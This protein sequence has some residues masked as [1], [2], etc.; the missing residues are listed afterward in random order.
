MSVHDIGACGI[1]GLKQTVLTPCMPD[2]VSAPAGAVGAPGAPD[3][4]VTL[5][6]AFPA[7]GDACG[8]AVGAFPPLVGG[9]P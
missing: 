8:G 3:D 1:V 7:P 2:P 4:G 9:V 6:G 5:P